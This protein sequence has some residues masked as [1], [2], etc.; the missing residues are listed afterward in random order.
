MKK[1]FAVIGNPPYQDETI[2]DNK[3]FAPPIYDKF[4]D[5]S[6][7]IAENVELI[8]PARFLVNAG[9]TPKMWNKKMLSDEHFKILHFEEDSSKIFPNTDIKGGVAVSFHSHSKIFGPIG[10]FTPNSKIQGILNKVIRNPN[11]E[12]LSTIIITS[13]AYHF[14][15]A[16]HKDYPKAEKMMS[17]GHAYDLKS[18]VFQNIPFVFADEKPNQGDYIRILGRL[19]NERVYKFIRTKYVNKVSNVDKYKIFLSGA[20]GRGGFGET[21]VDPIIGYPGDGSTET[22]LSMGSFSSKQEALRISKYVKTKFARCLLGILKKT[23]ANTP[24]KWKYVPLQDFT[25]KSDID[26]TKSVHEIDLQLYEKYGLSKEE[27]DFIETHVKEM[28]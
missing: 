19:N 6:Y 23:Q 5:E 27:K 9:S 13:Y 14:T 21:I 8:H 15:D 12:S 11:Y 1:F 22:F 2:G 16:L 17:K 18:N 4:I 25:S 20:M 3:T 7:E 28:V 10:V 24:E 26:W